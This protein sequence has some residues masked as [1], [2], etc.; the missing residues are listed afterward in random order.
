MPKKTR[1]QKQHAHHHRHQHTVVSHSV[2][3]ESQ[4]TDTASSLPV[5]SFTKSVSSSSSH[6]TESA[7]DESMSHIKRDLTKTMVL[8]AIAC[9]VLFGLSFIL[10]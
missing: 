6:H 1:K 3:G 9:A 4:N 7:F 5:Y 8:A 2:T 10:Q